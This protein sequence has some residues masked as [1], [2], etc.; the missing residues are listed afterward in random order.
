MSTTMTE[1]VAGFDPIETERLVL[2]PFRADDAEDYRTMMTDPE[3]TQYIGPGQW[4]RHAV[5][6]FFDRLVHTRDLRGYGLRAVA[7][8]DGGT[9]VGHCG[10]TPLDAARVELCYGFARSAWGKG[11]ATEAARA[12]LDHARDILG[13]RR[14]HGLVYPQNTASA[15]VLLKVGFAA[16]GREEHFDTLLDLYLLDL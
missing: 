12:A 15:A 6:R 16:V 5:D 1:P 4:P 14:V 8:R 13:L 7:E 10:I 2:R 9:V 3:A 11:Y